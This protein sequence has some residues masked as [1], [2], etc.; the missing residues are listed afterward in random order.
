VSDERKYRALHLVIRVCLQ[1][2][3]TSKGWGIVEQSIAV[4][5]ALSWT[6][7]VMATQALF[8]SITSAH[9]AER[10]FWQVVVYLGFFALVVVGQQLL[11]G[12][13]KYL[14]SKVSYTNVG[15]YMAEF[16]RK[17]GRLSAKN[18]ENTD[19]LNDINKTR[20]C[21]E[22]E[23]FGR[24]TSI[25]LQIFTY[26][27]V[28]FVSVGGY[29]F[30]LS[31][32][33]PIVILMAFIPAILGQL[34]QVKIFTELE[35]KNA[36][37]RRKCEYYKKTMTD[38]E[39]YKETRM[40]GGFSFFHNLF[41]NTLLRLTEKTWK[42]ERKGAMVRILLNMVSF[43][44]LGIS[45]FLL[46]KAT[47]A[48]DITI[49]AFV[50]VFVALSQIFSIMDEIVST[51]LSE[52]SASLGQVANYYRLMDMVEVDGE[53]KNPDFTNGIVAK[54][55]GFTYLGR[56]EATL[57]D[58]NVTINKGETIAIVGENGAGKSTLVRLLIGLYTPDT[59]TIEI[60]GQNIKTTHPN[61]TFKDISGV[62]QRFQRYKMTLAENVVISDTRN[63]LDIGK[64]KK[65][66][67]ESAFNNSTATLD[68]MLSPEFDGIDLSGGQWQR[69]AIARGLYRSSDLIVLDEPTAAI[70]PIEETQLYNQFR[71]LAKDKCTIIVTHRLGS[72]KLAD[73]IFVVDNGE[74]TDT[75]THD[76]L[77]ARAGKYSDMWK[78]QA[79]WYEGRLTEN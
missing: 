22:Y 65:T 77:L 54:N 35:E 67:E 70:D 76:E 43:A 29:L 52:W 73:R 48:G 13:A 74:I 17:L 72:I 14:F 62:F 4:L 32:V 20:D 41:I 33:L 18:F 78:A 55:M 16:Q 27:L 1:Y 21:L 68:T 59:G 15:K 37:L 57:R 40:L 25:C 64:V 42:T 23:R 2:F 5:R 12:S 50:A 51:Q 39:F 49:G 24:F 34:A 9:I 30:W 56:T 6:A 36:P 28:F 63:A 71:Y 47:M 79:S 69:L 45:I 58:I 38:R 8:D 46:F 10:D 19:F 66:L 3:K 61:A 75:G 31:P 60:G 7:G 53:H 44:G 26:Y 11:N